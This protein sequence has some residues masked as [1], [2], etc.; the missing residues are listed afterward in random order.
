MVK[1]YQ[2]VHSSIHR[3]YWFPFLV[4]V[5][6]FF[7]WQFGLSH[8]CYV[9]YVLHY[10][11]EQSRMVHIMQWNFSRQPLT[12]SVAVL[13]RQVEVFYQGSW[14]QL[15]KCL[16]YRGSLLKGGCLVRF[17]VLVLYHISSII[18]IWFFSL[19]TTISTSIN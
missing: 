11:P 1:I 17:T 7:T 15:F 9:L 12:V 18:E 16:T 19:V 6:F 13:Q 8:V 3:N 4:F 14:R 2:L 10:G 5:L